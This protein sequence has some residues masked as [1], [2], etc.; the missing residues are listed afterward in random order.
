M[1]PFSRKRQPSLARLADRA[2]DAGEWAVAAA[3]YSNALARDLRNPS[4]WVQYGHA[5][6]EAG[7]LRDPAKLGKAEAAYRRALIYAPRAA[8]THLQLGHVL[9][10]QGRADEAKAAYLRALAL[11]SALVTARDELRALGWDEKDSGVLQ[12]ALASLGGVEP[13]RRLWPSLIEQ[14]DAA[15]DAE[16]WRLAARRYR[17]V[18]ER[19]PGDAAIWVQHGHALKEAGN[20]KDPALLAEA[21]AAYYQALALKP[22]DA[23]THLQLGHVL[24][25]QGKGEEAEAAYVRA[26]VLDP[27][28]SAAEEL[29]SLGW[30]DQMV[31]EAQAMVD[32]GQSVGIES[33]Q[34]GRRVDTVE[35]W[36]I[37]CL[38]SPT[39]ADELG[40]FVTHAPRGRLKP[41]VA[42]YLQSL[43]RHG[44]AIV[45]VIAVDGPFDGVDGEL[46][47]HLNGIFIR[48]NA[49]YDF[50][51]WA[52]VLRLHPE[53]LNVG[54]LYLINDS[55]VGPTN[56][57]DFAALLATVRHNQA[58]FIGLT[59]NFER[60]WHIQSYFWVLKTRILSSHV[61]REFFWDI[62]SF[63]NKEDV[64]NNYEIKL[65]LRL[66]AAGFKC[67]A[68]FKGLPSPPER[69]W[70]QL[71]KAGFPFVKVRTIAG[72]SPDINH[73][74]WQE[75][76]RNRGYDIAVAER[77]IAELGGV[78]LRE[79][80][81]L[82]LLPEHNGPPIPSPLEPLAGGSPNEVAHHCFSGDSIPE[83]Y[84]VDRE[85]FE[86]IVSREIFFEQQSQ[87][88]FD[89]AE[90]AQAS[91]AYH[92]LISVIMPVYRTP[93]QWLRRA[94]ES[95]QEQYY[96][97]WELCAVDDCSPG[98]EQRALLRD[99][100]TIDPRVRLQVMERNGGISSA[101]NAALGMAQGE[102]VALLDHD[103][104]L[105]P[106]ALFRVVEAINR[107][108]DADFIY[109]DECKVD[110]TPARKLFDF[111]FKPD[112]SPEIMFNGM[113]TGHLTVY[114]KALVDELGGFRS[115]YDFSQDYD[116]ALRMA[117][118]ARR[119]VHVERLLYLW[120]SIPGSAAS[121]GK[122]YARE[123]NIG[124]LNDALRRRKI[125][126]QATPLPHANYVRIAVPA[127]TT[128]VS[129]IIPSDS[130]QNL[131]LALQ[132]IRDGTSYPNYEVVVVCNGPLAEY[133]E[134]EFVAWD[135]LLFVKYNK[136]F[137]F[138]DKCNEGARR[139]SGDIVIFYN[140]DVFPMQRD[141]IERLIEY[142]W[143]PGV[144]GVSPKLIYENASIQ[145][146]GM[147]SGTPGL[148]GTAYNG[149]PY[150]APV[151]FLQ[152]HKYV[153]NV[154]ILSG[155]C[156]AL[157]KDL[158]WMVGAFDTVNTPD[159]HSDMDLSY[160]LIEA[161]RRCVYTPHALLRHVGNHSW[162]AKRHKYKA[163]MFVLRRWGAYVSRDPYFT[164]S[165]K[166]VLYSDF[167][168]TYRIYA[169]H[170]RPRQIVT[171][172]DVLFVT[173]E[174]SQTGAPRMLFYAAL[175]IQQA[176]GFPV[177]VAPEDGPL[178]E[179][180]VR[181]GIVVIIDASIRLNHF[182][183]ERFA[184]NFDLAIVNTIALAEVVT[185]L[186]AIDIL[187]TVWWL[188]EAQS[189]SVFLREVQGVRWDHIH[190]LCVSTF[191]RS[192]V[193]EGIHAG[194]L[195]NG[196]PDEVVDGTE[197]RAQGMLTFVT[198][199]T[200]E[201]RKA[202]DILVE[203]VSLLPDHVRQQCRFLLT[204]K[205]WE[206]NR[207]YWQAVENTMKH[208][209][210][211]A[212]LGLLDH[213]AQL[214][215]IAAS[216]VLVCPSRDEPF[217]LVVAE[218]AMLSKP[219]I[220][221]NHVGIGEVFDGESCFIFEPESALSLAGQLLD[222][223]ER[224]DELSRM[225]QAARRVFEEY[226]DLEVF[227]K[228]FL[229]IVSEQIAISTRGGRPPK[230]RG[231]EASTA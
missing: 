219:S 88:S 20:L 31:A 47:Q 174:L 68:I 118:V 152:M 76:L 54:I 122:D 169:E 5:L 129:I 145:Y 114:R 99:L 70:R 131:R 137:N 117:E 59:E 100:A 74:G 116:L 105:P 149:A 139:A 6:K 119:I 194:I 84:H 112:W 52:H 208:L 142:L 202:Q 195:H 128:K 101:S 201:H 7:N 21:E 228:R 172:S 188:H 61:F 225:G 160:K 229:T 222:A 49:G 221:S 71:L 125:P 95:L 66:R 62:V 32:P 161:G 190:L 189:L 155:A 216:D 77:T 79:H 30:S 4:L 175:V 97:R 127:E 57:K 121:G 103:D 224:R 199:G 147:I 75:E 200:I 18:L 193:P 110:D 19:R 41:H 90:Q 198:A 26:F 55:V 78:E 130:A 58:D 64:I 69:Q 50:A 24:K 25:L 104:E 113:L 63:N 28:I 212:Y 93:I 123:S 87:L 153:R 33:P 133:L 197:E 67:E 43:I 146:A 191:A 37:R 213:P 120:R 35:D 56:D 177:V 186:S 13:P 217:S 82:P 2:R 91:F 148:C 223:F 181:A 162:S 17:A 135:R 143:V 109:S 203:A 164:E 205:L 206:M 166:R 29:R 73:D 196:L 22:G 39:A 46:A 132:A 3:L 136:K 16:Q 60:L 227:G 230:H 214:R 179:E 85:P 167:R 231:V 96:E 111:T 165:M 184:R 36:E 180:M 124:A 171:G 15:R 108:P 94:V 86:L 1:L 154:S 89:S 168:F 220:L 80:A 138:S 226:L 178:R 187:R 182:L 209:P 207:E 156:C 126:G 23:D 42:H 151:P 40:I 106:D 140:D 185:Q 27:F 141:W 11:D 210:E 102:Y 218:A 72:M 14:A 51:A 107:E 48:Q 211:I 83:I 215:L 53:L 134:D 170:I 204:G 163:D 81:T 157:W 98:D 45:L 9:K 192:L 176:G 12:T 8:D 159:G 38:K 144:G 44:V 34:T 173:H 65:P 115:E 92:P 183:F 10:L 150:D 158:F